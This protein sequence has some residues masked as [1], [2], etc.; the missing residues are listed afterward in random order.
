MVISRE[1]LSSLQVGVSTLSKYPSRGDCAFKSNSLTE[2]HHCAA[3]R[4]MGATQIQRQ[5][6]KPTQHWAVPST[7]QG[8]Q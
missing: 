7:L 8:A 1:M 6:T 5:W 3:S 4:W 2:W